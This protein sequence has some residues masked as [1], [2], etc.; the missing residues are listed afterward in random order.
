MADE[1]QDARERALSTA[2]HPSGRTASKHTSMQGYSVVLSMCCNERSIAVN[3]GTP[4][5]RP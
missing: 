3:G 2:K 5:R 1:N 4:G